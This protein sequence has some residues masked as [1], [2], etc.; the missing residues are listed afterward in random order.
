MCGGRGEA[1]ECIYGA[2][3]RHWF[4]QGQAEQLKPA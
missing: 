3:I 4:L 1:E 2:F